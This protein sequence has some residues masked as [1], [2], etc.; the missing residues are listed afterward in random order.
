ML[1]KFP[2]PLRSRVARPGVRQCYDDM[3]RTTEKL[4]AALDASGL[5]Q[6]DVSRKSGV[7]TGALSEFLAGKRNLRFDQVAR[8]A[9][10]LGVSL[11]YLADDA[12][13]E[14]P[15]PLGEPER[16]AVDFI[17]AKELTKKEVI[18]RLTFDPSKFPDVE[19]PKPKRS[20]RA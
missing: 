12:A 19:V 5:K 14:P 9:R 3:S 2:E 20:R 10:A 17:Q 8:I 6:A 16:W 18:D 7:S 11:D 4:E 1:E 15:A 13:K